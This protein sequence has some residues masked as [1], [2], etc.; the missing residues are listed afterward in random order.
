M[1]AK[2]TAIKAR[3]DAAV[4]ILFNLFQGPSNASLLSAISLDE[5]IS[6]LNASS[7]SFKGIFPKTVTPNTPTK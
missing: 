2:T 3:M 6:M 1:Q 7:D 5:A 4:L